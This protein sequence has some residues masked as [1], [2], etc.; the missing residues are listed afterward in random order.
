M[1]FALRDISDELQERLAEAGYRDIRP[2]HG[3][4]FA[5][6]GN[7][8]ARLTELADASRITKQAMGEL[9]SDLERLGYLERIPDPTDGCARILRLTEQGKEAQR[10]GFAIL[11]DIERKWAERY[12]AERVREL[13]AVLAQ[14]AA[15]GRP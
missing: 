10:A 15:E 2:P 11:S 7:D 4:V 6:I 13:R 14:H 3:F 12:G 1:S 8:G 9:T 5:V